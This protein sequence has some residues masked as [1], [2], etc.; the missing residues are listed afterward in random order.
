MTVTD[1]FSPSAPLPPES[2][3]RF[4]AS[5]ARVS[6]TGAPAKEGDAQQAV[7]EKAPAG[8]ELK[9]YPME[10]SKPGQEPH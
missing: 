7:S 5:L 3:Q 8:S 4:I 2:G 9:T 6:G 1:I 10:D